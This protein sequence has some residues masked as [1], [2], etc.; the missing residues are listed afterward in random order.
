MTQE[1]LG[2]KEVFLK[3]KC[4]YGRER[5]YAE[6]D[7]SKS[8]LKLMKRFVFSDRELSIF[9]NDDWLIWVDSIIYNKGN[10]N[11]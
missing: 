11:E 8:I 1:K 4:S 6:C 3:K 9:L 2:R 7:V 10:V 5:Y